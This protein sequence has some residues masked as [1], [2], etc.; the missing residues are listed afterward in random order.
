MGGGELGNV[1]LATGG[2]RVAERASCAPLSARP[3]RLGRQLGG[4]ELGSAGKVD[5][6]WTTH[7]RALDR[8]VDCG[9]GGSRNHAC[10]KYSC[11]TESGWPRAPGLAAKYA[12]QSIE[13]VPSHWPRVPPELI[14]VM[15]C[16][17]A[18]THRKLVL[19]SAHGV[20]T[21]PVLSIP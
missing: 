2:R 19:P 11:P 8:L 20:G 15:R 12:S 13:S 1:D 9:A 17:G 21:N 14:G 16:A 5:Q 10:P 4:A 6:G 18:L 7:F 3:R